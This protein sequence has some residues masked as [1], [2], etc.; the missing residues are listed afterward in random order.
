[1]FCPDRI[2]PPLRAMCNGKV[3]TSIGPTK[4]LSA[5]LEKKLNCKNGTKNFIAA[6]KK[7][8]V[9]KYSVLS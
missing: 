2:V 3:R 7:L 1:M 8:G 6:G 4:C 5:C 9:K